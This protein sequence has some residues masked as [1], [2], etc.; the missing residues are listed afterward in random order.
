MHAIILFMWILG[1]LKTESMFFFLPALFAVAIAISFP[2]LGDES[3]IY[4]FIATALIDSGHV[5]TTVWRT[6]FHPEERRSSH[7]YWTFPFLI[8]LFFCCWYFF[9]IPGLWSFVVYSTLFHHVRQVYGFSKWYQALNKRSDRISD[10]FLY[11]LSIGPMIVYHF[12]LDA[13]GDYY[14]VGD[15]FIYRSADLFKISISLYALIVAGW[16]LYEARLWNK[17]I[18]ETNRFLSIAVPAVVYGYCFLLS[19]TFTQ[20]LFPLLFLHGISYCGVMGISLQRTR[21]GWFSTI[22]KSLLIVGVTAIV[23]GVFESMMEETIVG[24]MR[25]ENGLIP[26]LII[27][28]YLTPLYCHYLFDAMIWKRSHRESKLIFGTK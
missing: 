24:D 14:S 23:F 5:Y 22:T 13:I 17:G 10:Y 2:H 15:L 8:C 16:L 21:S 9:K 7:V 18:K 6:F 25:K 3:V 26:S 1:S 27:G 11:A 20:L 12:R 19:R 28:L 4:G